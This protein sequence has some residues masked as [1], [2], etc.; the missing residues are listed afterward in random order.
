MNSYIQITA[1]KR[2]VLSNNQTKF[3]SHLKQL[4]PLLDPA[5]QKD[6]Q[7]LLECSVITAEQWEKCLHV[8]EETKMRKEQELAVLKEQAHSAQLELTVAQQQLKQKE[9]EE[10]AAQQAIENELRSAEDAL[11][12]T[13]D[14]LRV[15]VRK[16]GDI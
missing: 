7:S 13:R 14:L 16:K 8:L 2:A 6:L 1:G 12:A 15:S 5:S 9:V 4:L 11:T 10:G 3:Q